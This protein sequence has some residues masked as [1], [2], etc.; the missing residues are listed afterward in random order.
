M[1][2]HSVMVLTANLDM[3]INC[4]RS[5]NLMQL[6]GISQQ[7]SFRCPVVKDTLHLSLVLTVILQFTPERLSSAVSFRFFLQ[8]SSYVLILDYSLLFS[9]V[10][11]V[12]AM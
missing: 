4:L 8:V 7:R 6:N 1:C 5:Q 11:V 9:V 3:A 2:S 10:V 12:V